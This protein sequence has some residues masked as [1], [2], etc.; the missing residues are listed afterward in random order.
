M[1]CS[2]VS[3]D[4]LEEADGSNGATKI[5]RDS[6]E[7]CRRFSRRAVLRGIGAISV[8]ALTATALSSTA[9]A[10]VT[11]IESPVMPG[12]T[13]GKHN[14]N[15]KRGATARNYELGAVLQYKDYDPDTNEHTFSMSWAGLCSIRDDRTVKSDGIGGQFLHIDCPESVE[16]LGPK[17]DSNKKGIGPVDRESD[18]NPGYGKLLATA[19]GSCLVAP[20]ITTPGTAL[21][22]FV[23]G[24]SEIVKDYLIFDGGEKPDGYWIHE[25]YTDASQYEI[26]HGERV[27]QAWGFYKDFRLKD[28]SPYDSDESVVHIACGEGEFGGTGELV[29]NPP[30]DVEYGRQYLKEQALTDSVWY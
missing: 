6:T 5:P 18:Y 7:T 4:D 27:E 3:E 24:G 29:T 28:P 9:A 20:V 15:E 12:W 26:I 19:V 23:M 30:G 14:R 13:V 10:E 25:S 1:W 8:S 22:G 2:H 16:H 11:P 21:P 17:G